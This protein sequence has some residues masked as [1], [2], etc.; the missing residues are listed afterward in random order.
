MTNKETLK[1]TLKKAYS[2]WKAAY[3][4]YADI[5]YAA[6]I[7][8]MKM[9]GQRGM[10]PEA[11]KILSSASRTNFSDETEKYKAVCLDA[12]SKYEEELSEERMKA[13]SEEAVRVLE[14]L[15]ITGIPE[16][17]AADKMQEYVD[18]YGDNYIFFNALKKIAEDGGLSVLGE[19]PL[20]EEKMN[21][22]SM[23]ENVKSTFNPVSAMARGFDAVQEYVFNMYAD[24]LIKSAD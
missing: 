12:L 19:H 9:S 1:N 4:R 24:T 20:E 23:I 8:Q 14:V 22:D 5:D 11:G 21:C 3:N 16:K 15:K 18:A 10:L 6:A 2:D 13:P 7:D 17:N